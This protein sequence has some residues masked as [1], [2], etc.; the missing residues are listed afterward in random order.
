MN[1]EAWLDELKI[2]HSAYRIVMLLPPIYVAWADGRIQ[3]AERQLIMEIARTHGLLEEGGGEILERWL[4]MAPTEAQMKT[5][6]KILNELSRSDGRR[7]RGFDA[8]T[9]VLLLAWCQDVADA[10]GGLLGLRAARHPVETEALKRVAAALEIANSKNW[11]A[12][13]A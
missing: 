10:A 3:P 9:E 1:I 5:D 13:F 7:G 8:D 12:L 6:L 4:S 11:S 2:P